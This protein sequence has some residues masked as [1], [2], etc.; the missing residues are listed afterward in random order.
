MPR[1]D[2]NLIMHHLS[3]AL[4]IKPIKQKLRK[5]H[6]HVTLLVKAEVKKLLKTSLLELLTMLNGFLTVPVSKHDKSIQVCIDL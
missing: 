5:M 1:L 4:G 3:I 6:P 2:L